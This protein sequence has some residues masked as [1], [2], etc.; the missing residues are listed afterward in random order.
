M[1]Q[2][3]LKMYRRDR[4]YASDKDRLENLH[5]SLK[6]V[7]IVDE[8]AYFNSVPEGTS[9]P[10]KATRNHRDGVPPTHKGGKGDRGGGGP[11]GAGGGSGA[12]GYGG[13]YGGK[14]GGNLH[15]PEKG[16]SA[17]AK[18]SEYSSHN[19]GQHRQNAA[20]GGAG[21][22]SAAAQA[23]HDA[24]FGMGSSPDPSIRVIKGLSDITEPKRS[25][26]NN[27]AKIGPKGQKLSSQSV[28]RS[29]SPGKMA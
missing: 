13:G 7:R 1:T 9:S 20:A 29:S 22:M 27:S 25:K 12:A 8:A 28:N 26:N 10:S 14:G 15:P 19:R 6:N 2:G 18:G 23:M 11:S 24:M 17:N 4:L 5:N 21:A 3:K 16:G